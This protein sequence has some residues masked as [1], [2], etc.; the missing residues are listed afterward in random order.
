MKTITISLPGF[1]LLLAAQAAFGQAPAQD[2]AKQATAT[3]VENTKT[4]TSWDILSNLYQIGLNDLTA[5]DKSVKLKSTI[6]GLHK[7]FNPKINDSKTYKELA[8]ERHF[9]PYLNM[10]Y[11]NKFDPSNLT[12]GFNYSF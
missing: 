2:A 11:K 6:Y 8:F 5:D 4:L 9:E 1:V 10:D 7:L 12:A 3:K